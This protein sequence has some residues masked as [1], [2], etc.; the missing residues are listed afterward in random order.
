MEH[1]VMDGSSRAGVLNVMRERGGQLRVEDLA[2]AVGLSLSA[3]RFHLDRLIT[4]GLVRSA[5]EPRLTP[6]RPRV[7]Y[8]ALAE[9]AVDDAAAYR[10]LAA[11]LADELALHGGG[12]AAEHAGRSWAEQLMK[13]PDHGSKPLIPV[14]SPRTSTDSSPGTA[15]DSLSDVLAVLENGGFS[16]RV[17]DGGWTIELHRCPFKELMPGQSEV[18]CTVHRGL[19][20]AIP[21]VNGAEDR[22]QLYPA[23]DAE[24]PC[25]VRFR[26]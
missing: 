4:D 16:P 23:P 14:V 26:H 24:A 9:E 2:E 7:I 8:Q 5:R 3:V 11:L 6:G 21:D 15:P 20:K 1:R 18:V 22:V 12:A 25:M 17:M 10:R 19:L 13:P